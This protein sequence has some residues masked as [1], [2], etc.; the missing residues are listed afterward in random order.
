M[1]HEHNEIIMPPTSDVDAAIGAVMA[2]FSEHVDED[3]DTRFSFWDWYVIGGRWSGAKTESHL[4]PDDLES[5]NKWMVDEKV[6]VSALQF[7]KQTLA[8]ESTKQKVDAKWREL[9]PDAG[10]RC[11]LFDHSNA[12]NRA[13]PGDV[14]RLYEVSERL[15]AFRVVIAGPRYTGE[16][17]E[18]VDR[19][20]RT[21][22]NGTWFVD[23]A[24]D[25]NVLGAVE[26][27]RE[28]AQ[29]MLEE[30]R[31]RVMPRHDWLVVTVDSHT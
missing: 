14:C 11:T 30:Y 2:P 17:L 18:A 27:F 13:L 31:E 5:F 3:A 21:M 10:P 8:D 23:T 20:E 22:Y 1:S 6:M 29:R 24:W 25:G 28:R 12:R 16:G 19:I 15:T 4:D 26:R 9:F 7:G